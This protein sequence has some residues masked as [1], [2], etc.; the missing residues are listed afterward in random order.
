MCVCVFPLLLL[1]LCCC[2]L[3]FVAAAV[4][5]ERFLRRRGRLLMSAFRYLKVS[6]FHLFSILLHFRF[7]NFAA[8]EYFAPGIR[9]HGAYLRLR[10]PIL[11]K[12]SKVCCFCRALENLSSS[13]QVFL[14]FAF[15]CSSH[16]SFHLRALNPS[17][18]SA[19]VGVGSFSL[20]CDGGGL[21]FVFVVRTTKIRVAWSNLFL[22]WTFSFI[23]LPAAFPSFSPL[24]SISSCLV[25]T[26]LF[27]TTFC[28]FSL[29][30]FFPKYHVLRI[31]LRN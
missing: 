5:R 1:R 23:F 31:W 3:H 16:F 20:C 8:A 7:V 26:R 21:R 11:A 13:V 18:P 2:S 17:P 29:S 19:T 4:V 12:K 15:F 25:L 27:L 22:Y 14:F 28:A 30:G 6:R 9:Q 10:L 24:G